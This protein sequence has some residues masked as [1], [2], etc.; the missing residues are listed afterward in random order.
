MTTLNANNSPLNAGILQVLVSRSGLSWRLHPAQWTAIENQ[1]FVALCDI[2]DEISLDGVVP[3]NTVRMLSGLPVHVDE[4]APRHWIE[5]HLGDQVIARI[6][7]L[8]I[9]CGMEA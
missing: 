7:N 2:V 3:V 4:T 6:E 1:I 5:L 8:A 9:P